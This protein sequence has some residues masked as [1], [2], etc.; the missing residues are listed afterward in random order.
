MAVEGAHTSPRPKER[1]TSG[2]KCMPPSCRSPGQ[3]CASPST[4]DGNSR[5]EQRAREWR[6]RPPPW[7]SSPSPAGRRPR[8]LGL[9]ASTTLRR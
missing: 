6:G 8:G 9:P 4:G 5:T 2:A 7:W 3:R 1:T